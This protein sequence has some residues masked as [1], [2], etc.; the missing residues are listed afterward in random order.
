MAHDRPWSSSGDR[1][2]AEVETVYDGLHLRDHGT[3]PFGEQPASTGACHPVPDIKC[4]ITSIMC[5]CHQVAF[6]GSET[7]RGFFM[8]DN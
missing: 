8:V 1:C 2:T 3:H 6:G 7:R 5:L 4:N